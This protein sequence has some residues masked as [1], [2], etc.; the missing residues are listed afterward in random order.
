[1]PQGPRLEQDGL[2]CAALFAVAVC[3]LILIVSFWR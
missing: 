2:A 3:I 1:M